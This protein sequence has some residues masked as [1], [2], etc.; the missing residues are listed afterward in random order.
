M[1]RRPPRSTLFPYTTLFRSLSVSGF[2]ALPLAVVKDCI[3][4]GDVEIFVEGLAVDLLCR[5]GIVDFRPD[6]FIVRVIEIFLHIFDFPG[7]GADEEQR[8]AVSEALRVG[9]A[10]FDAVIG[11][12]LLGTFDGVDSL[13]PSGKLGGHSSIISLRSVDLPT[14]GLPTMPTKPDFM[15]IS[16]SVIK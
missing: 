10:G 9:N 4:D 2:L 5:S 16:F 7:L 6:D 14:L 8:R 3:H 15:L 13:R 12:G 11:D 1:I